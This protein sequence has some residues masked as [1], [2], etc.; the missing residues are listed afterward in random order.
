MPVLVTSRVA[1]ASKLST[2]L[3]IVP[4][5]NGD[6]PPAVLATLDAALGGA[7]GSAWSSGDFAGKRDQTAMLYPAGPI[8]RVL[9]IGIGD[10]GKVDAAALRRAAMI[11]G[12]RARAA[13]VAE[14]TLLV[15]ESAVASDRVGQVLAEGIPFGAWHYPEYKKPAESPKPELASVELI[16]AEPD[17][18]FDSGVARGNA[19]ATGQALTRRLQVLPPDTCTPEFLAQEARQLAARHGMTVTILEREQ[20]EAEGMGGILAVGKGSVNPPRFIV[21]EHRGAGEQ[22]V[23]LVGKGVTFDTGGISIKPATNMEEMKYDMSGAAAVLGTMEAVGELALARHVVA[24]VPSAENMV[25]SRAYRPGDIVR[26]HSGKTVEVINTDAEG[27]LLLADA[28]S[29]AKRFEPAAVV[30]CATL[31]G[32]VVISLG[33]AASAVLGTDD[34][35]VE[36]LRLAGL[37]ADERI[38]QLPIWDD[39]RELIKSD[40]ADM[41]NSAGRPA[42]TITAAWFLREHVGEYP[43]AHIDIA[44]TA[45]LGNSQPTQEKGATGV[46]VRLFS[47]FLLARG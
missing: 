10:A 35:L 17:A 5:A 18:A 28:L 1:D 40:I 12:K 34:T 39:Y 46:L 3:L 24:L 9:L 8:T 30:D 47:E 11:A 2:P 15:P 29:Y 23:V 13:G 21:L 20:L 33:H 27:R 25:S 42:G 22:P 41:K 19:I 14:A 44:G 45:Y 43:W 37:A 31:T 38:W 36:E 16:V 7:I 32:A 6:A 4:V 26:A